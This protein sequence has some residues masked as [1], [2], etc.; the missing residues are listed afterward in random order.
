M[1]AQQL[2]GL[3][4]EGAL[5]QAFTFLIPY[6]SGIS[7]NTAVKNRCTTIFFVR[8]PLDKYISPLHKK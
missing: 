3:S 7:G 4:K 2:V 1:E 6:F 8:I 5:F